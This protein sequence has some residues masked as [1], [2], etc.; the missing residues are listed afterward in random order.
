MR[1]VPVPFHP[2]K[3]RR[4]RVRR[5][6]RKRKLT[7]LKSQLVSISV[8]AA[9]PGPNELSKDEKEQERTSS[10]SKKEN[11]KRRPTII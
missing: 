6:K 10:L 8:L 5:P 3:A 11:G 9:D 2:L 1:C 7:C 4:V